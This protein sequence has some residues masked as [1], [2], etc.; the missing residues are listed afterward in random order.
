MAK[1]IALIYGGESC[2]HD[3]SIITALGVYNAVKWDYNITLV[4]MKN[5]KFFIGEKL[6]EIKTYTDFNYKNFKEI[7][8]SC[9]HMFKKKKFSF[10][11]RKIDCALLCNH[12]GEG[13]NGSLSGYLEVA[14]IPY[15]ACAPFASSLCMDKVFTKYLLEKFR[16]PVVGYKVFKKENDI[17][18][19][20]DLGYPVIIKPARL[21]SS[22]GISIANDEESLKEAIAHGLLFDEKLLIEKALTEFTEYNCAVCQCDGEILT[23]EIEKPIFKSGY[24]NFYDKYI[25]SENIRELPAQMP[26]KVREKLFSFCRQIYTIFE[27]KGV[28]RID[29]LYKDEKLYVNEINTIP[30]SLSTYL[31]KAKGIETLKLIDY[32]IENGIKVY[33]DAKK[34]VKDFS[35]NVLK[36]FDLSKLKSGI[37]K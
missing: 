9:G 23:S 17:S 13:E 14:Q 12:G 3:I 36:N 11:K 37:K 21:G 2:E 20:H 34:Q 28:V 10:E 31:F 1:N 5:G 26:E 33:V 35:S 6:S 27:L 19:L 18:A 15:T 32:M 16:F 30:G 22:V 4:Y 24:L 29:F 8:F 7:F 25:S